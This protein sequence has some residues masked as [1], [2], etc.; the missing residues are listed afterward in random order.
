MEDYYQTFKALHMISIIAWMAGLLYLPRLFVYH[1]TVKA[2]SEASE[3]FK[4][5]ERRLL[6]AIMHPAMVVSYIFGVLMLIELGGEAWEL[7]WMQVKIACII[8]LTIIHFQM[9]VWR[10]DFERDQNVRS[11]KF[12]RIMNEVP[13]I[14]MI[15]IVFMVILQPF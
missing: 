5:M 8:A 13:T 10:K 4:I 14:L 9:G 15:L 2:G 7:G 11:E 1:C 3:T 6:W 12:F